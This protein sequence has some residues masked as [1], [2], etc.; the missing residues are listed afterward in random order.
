MEFLLK[1][2]QEIWVPELV[3]RDI[4][5]EIFPKKVRKIITFS[6][7]RRSGKTYIMFQLIKELSKTHPKENIFYINFEDER[8]ERK[9]D[10]LKKTLERLL[11]FQIAVLSKLVS[12]F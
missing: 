7:S 1:E 6:G 9:K 12:T 3:D 8:L 2:W 5:L 4:S 10:S 11:I